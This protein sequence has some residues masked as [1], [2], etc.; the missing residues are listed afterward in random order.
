MIDWE[1]LEGYLAVDIAR[2]RYGPGIDMGGA[3][4]PKPS[5]VQIAHR[6]IEM[7]KFNLGNLNKLC[8]VCDLGETGMHKNCVLR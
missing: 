3:H 2:A 6:F 8:P 1:T 5:E 7:V 4:N